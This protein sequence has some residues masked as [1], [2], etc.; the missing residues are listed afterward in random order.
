MKGG[1]KMG[2]TPLFDVDINHNGTAD[3]VTVRGEIDLVSAPQ[4]RDAFADLGS[5]VLVDLRGVT[6]IDSS[7][8]AVLI[9][10]KHKMMN[11]GDL[12]IVA[13]SPPVLRLFEIAG[14]TEFF[15]PI[16]DPV[17]RDSDAE[18]NEVAS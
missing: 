8:L 7:G 6:F 9:D 5:Q 18:S 10:Q 12:R 11:G 4:L 17:S 15:K 2:Q 3:T 1:A 14:L 13:N 16:P